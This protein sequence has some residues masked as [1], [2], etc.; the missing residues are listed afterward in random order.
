MSSSTRRIPQSG[1]A[2][3]AASAL[4]QAVVGIEF[5]LSGLNKFADPRFTQN[6]NAFVRSSPGAQRGLFAPLIQNLILPNV[7]LVALTTKWAETLL[8]IIL[9]VGAAEIARRR[10]S[11]RFGRA[12]GYEALVAVIAAA[13]GLV[14]AGLSLSI[15][16]L[17]GGVLPTIQPGRAFTSAIPVELLIVPLG[18]AIAWLEWGRYRV[19]RR[20]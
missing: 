12:H 14:T 3:L 17:E 11:G 4:I 9:V 18:L 6:F 7:S 2:A 19:L 5:L 20:R 16:L 1:N 10:F 8:G 13:A 15:F